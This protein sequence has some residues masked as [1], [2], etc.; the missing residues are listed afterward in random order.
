MLPQSDKLPQDVK[1]RKTKYYIM[2]TAKRRSTMFTTKT[3]HTIFLQ[4]T[5]LYKYIGQISLSLMYAK[6]SYFF[7]GPTLINIVGRMLASCG[8]ANTGNIAGATAAVFIN[9]I[10]LFLIYCVEFNANESS[11]RSHMSVN[12]TFCFQ[13]C[14]SPR[15]INCSK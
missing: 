9:T 1:S 11:H 12:T 6:F 4:N 3:S 5:Q 7:V 14:C 15:E 8:W 2:L 13:K 10:V